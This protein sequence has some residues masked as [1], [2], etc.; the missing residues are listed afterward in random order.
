MPLPAPLHP[1][2]PT[3][4]V[5]H[6]A[7]CFFT[8]FPTPV[9]FHVPCSPPLA[10][11]LRLPPAPCRCGPALLPQSLCPSLRL[12]LSL[13]S[14]TPTPH[15]YPRGHS[16]GVICC[17]GLLSG[18]TGYIESYSTSGKFFAPNCTVRCA[19]S[20][21]LLSSVAVRVRGPEVGH[22]LAGVPGAMPHKDLKGVPRSRPVPL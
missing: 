19:L 3:L 5:V 11:A 9:V 18:P 20:P 1:L 16:L 8:H 13:P 12:I 10:R 6:R 17:L 14:P 7:L 21:P 4:R 2:C 15:I 22:V